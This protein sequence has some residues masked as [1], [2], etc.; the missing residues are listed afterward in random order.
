[1]G[2]ASI[3]GVT[4]RRERRWTSAGETPARELDRSAAAFHCV[5]RPAGEAGNRLVPDRVGTYT[6]CFSERTGIKSWNCC[7]SPCVPEVKLFVLFV[8]LCALTRS[9]S[10]WG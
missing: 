8:A 1:M 7:F 10:K 4:V 5:L 9:E 3:V 6:R 2:G